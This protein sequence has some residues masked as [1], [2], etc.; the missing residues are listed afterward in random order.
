MPIPLI[1]KIRNSQGQRSRSNVTNFQPLLAQICQKR[2]EM[3]GGT[4]SVVAAGGGT[5]AG[6][7]GGDDS[8]SLSSKTISG[9]EETERGARYGDELYR[10]QT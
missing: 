4:G 7:S 1:R 9:S 6:D 3:G 8:R 5:S 10:H 2:V